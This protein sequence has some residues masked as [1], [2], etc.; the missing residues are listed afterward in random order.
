MTNDAAPILSDRPGSF[1][2]GVWNQ[3]HPILLKRI[4]ETFPYPAEVHQALE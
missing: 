2:W 3:R 4:R 1:S